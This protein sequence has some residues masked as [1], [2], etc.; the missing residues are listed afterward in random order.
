MLGG[1]KKLQE[2]EVSED[3]WGRGWMLED[4]WMIRRIA[5]MIGNHTYKQ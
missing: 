3:P 2:I 5:T 1:M 4:V